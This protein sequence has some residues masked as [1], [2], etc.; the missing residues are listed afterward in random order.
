MGWGEGESISLHAGR[1]IMGHGS[2]R[3]IKIVTFR[4]LRTSTWLDSL[5]FQV[6]PQVRE[7]ASLFRGS[8]P[9]KNTTCLQHA[10]RLRAKPC[11]TL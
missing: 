4:I 7:P 6:S 11:T 3:K 1:E 10:W 2:E 5:Y 9:F 8:S